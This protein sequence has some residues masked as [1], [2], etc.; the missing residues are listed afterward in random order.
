MSAFDDIFNFHDAPIIAS[1][2][3]PAKVGDAWR[4]DPK[5]LAIRGITREEV[6]TPCGRMER[7]TPNWGGK[8][9]AKTSARND[10]V[11]EV[12]IT[13][14]DAPLGYGKFKEYSIVWISENQ[15]SYYN[16]M[17]ENVDKFKKLAD[18][19]IK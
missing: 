6:Y 3:E 1:A 9:P 5:W 17:Y 18:K 15:P 12:K 13:G 10:P 8:Q 2:P 4:K 19:W 16:W 14:K 7:F 11:S